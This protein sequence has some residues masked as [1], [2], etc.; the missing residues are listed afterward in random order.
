[1]SG[2]LKC[3]VPAAKVTARKYTAHVSTIFTCAYI[4]LYILTY[5]YVYTC[6]YH[7]VITL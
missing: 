1:M 5:I 4:Y 6:A 7:K 3:R 2:G